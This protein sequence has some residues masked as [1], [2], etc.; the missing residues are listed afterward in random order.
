MYTIL[1]FYNMKEN[2]KF[3]LALTLHIETKY[4]AL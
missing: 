4:K 2:D 3:S 1:F